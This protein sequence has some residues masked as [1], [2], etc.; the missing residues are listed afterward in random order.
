MGY[1]RRVRFGDLRSGLPRLDFASE[2]VATLGHP[3]HGDKAAAVPPAERGEKT[4]PGRH[5]RRAQL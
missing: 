1:S 3:R 4:E 2:L 5:A